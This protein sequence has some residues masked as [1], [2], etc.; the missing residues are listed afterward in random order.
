[1]SPE[2]TAP[3]AQRPATGWGKLLATLFRNLSRRFWFPAL[4]TLAL[5]GAWVASAGLPL[6]EDSGR[7]LTLCAVLLGA[8]GSLLLVVPALAQFLGQQ[9]KAKDLLSERSPT[10]ENP[11]I[12]KSPEQD[13]TDPT[14][15]YRLIVDL[16][17]ALRLSGETV[18]LYRE[19]LLLVLLSFLLQAVPPGFALVGL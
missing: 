10:Q 5:C 14:N 19:G 12:V 4:A 17:N 8:Y 9:Q 3:A 11:A 1:M 18:R 6:T 16:E 2:K 7:F 13:L 15:L